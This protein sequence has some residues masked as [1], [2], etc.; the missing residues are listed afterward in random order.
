MSRLVNLPPKDRLTMRTW[1]LK[2]LPNAVLLRDLALLVTRDRSTTAALLA[3]LAEFDA[4]RLYAPAGY[5]SMHAW[6][7]AVLRFSDDAAYKRIRAAR[8]ARDF[9]AIFDAVA[10]GRLHLTA[11]C[12]VSAHLTAGNVDELILLVTHRLSADVRRLLA[13]RFPDP[14][15]PMLFA[16]TVPP[17]ASNSASVPEENTSEL[18]LK[19]VVPN[20]ETP[21][22]P[23]IS[24]SLPP[25]AAALPPARG[26]LKLAISAPT[27]EKLAHAQALLS[28]SVPT[29]DLA[30][31]FDRA[32][33]ALIER[34]EKR[35]FAS[36]TR[37]RAAPTEPGPT[38]RG[39]PAHVRRAVWGRDGGRCTFVGDTGHRCETR[40]FLEFDHVEPVAR[41]GRGMTPGDVRLRCRTHNRLE[42]ERAFGRDFVQ[43]RIEESRERPGEVPPPAPP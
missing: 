31:I 20:A 22:H 29:G 33:D 24:A 4:R 10:T 17:P 35:K 28:H 9:P 7:V 6:C 8:T 26:L 5:D 42:A 19:P 12:L 40:R 36:S 27:R 18:V 32:L 1:T 15:R 14:D 21:R 39:I 23:A 43:R 30:E 13:E 25:A 2:H 34:L 11:V 16:A 3:Y 41:G 38:K 37:P